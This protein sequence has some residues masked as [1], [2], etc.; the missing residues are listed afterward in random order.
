MKLTIL[1][2]GNEPHPFIQEGQGDEVSVHKM[3]DLFED[4]V[5]F[6]TVILRGGYSSHLTASMI[7]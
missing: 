2:G 7:E 3:H 4:I 6:K 5:V 1:V